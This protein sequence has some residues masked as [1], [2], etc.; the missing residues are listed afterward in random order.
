MKQEIKQSRIAVTR[1]VVVCAPYTFLPLPGPMG[2]PTSL[3]LP[4]ED[5]LM[6]GKDAICTYHQ[7]SLSYWQEAINS[8]PEDQRPRVLISTSAVGERLL[9]QACYHP[10]RSTEQQHISLLHMRPFAVR[11]CS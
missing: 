1:Q 3:Q 7:A 8:A 2:V 4:A 6:T 9:P 10:S 5:C 11:L